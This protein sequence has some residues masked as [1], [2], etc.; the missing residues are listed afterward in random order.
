MHTAA[1]LFFRG[2]SPDILLSGDHHCRSFKDQKLDDIVKTV[3]KDYPSNLFDKTQV[4]A[5]YKET[6]PYV[7]QYNETNFEFLANGWQKNM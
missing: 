4:S 6:I 7:V 3:T 1:Q 2:A 5:R